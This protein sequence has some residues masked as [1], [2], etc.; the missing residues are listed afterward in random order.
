HAYAEAARLRGAE[1]IEH[2]RVTCI[3]R[4]PDGWRLETELGTI[5]AEHLVN[6]AGLWARR[7]G[8]MVGIDHPLV[9]MPHHYL[10]TDDIP[11]VAAIDGDMVAVTDLEG[12]T[13][14]QREGNGVLLGVYELNPRHWKVDGADWDFGRTLFPPELDRIMPELSIG[15]KRFPVLHDIGIKKWVNGAFT[16]TPDGN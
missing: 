5:T 9:P 14:L 16:F 11:E 2:N 12:Y 3:D 4:D 13:Y 7:V 15:F 10:V 8:N 1:V 6:A